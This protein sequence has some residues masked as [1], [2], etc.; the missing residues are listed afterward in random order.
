MTVTL[1]L[2]Q[3]AAD[4]FERV[5]SLLPAFAERA[6]EHDASDA[7]VAN[8]YALLKDARIFSAG[9]PVELGGDGLDAASLARLLTMIAKAC[10]ST[11]LALAM[12]THTVAVLAWR[13]RN[14]KA[15]VDA[16]L[17]RIAVEQ[18]VIITTGGSDWLE[19]S[20]TAEKVEGGFAIRG[21][22][23][24]ASGVPAGT[25]LNTSAVYDDPES[26]PTVLH[27]MVPL[28]AKGVR[29][30]PTWRAM[31]MRATASHLVHLEGYVVPDAAIALRRPKGKWHPLFHTIVMIAI[32]IIYSVYY[33]VAEAAR[34]AAIATAKKKPPTPQLVDLVGEMETELAAAR[35]ALADMLANASGTPGPE[36]TNRTFLGRVNLVRAALAAT[37][38][39]MEVT[40][41]AG[42]MR[43]HPVE[44][45]FRDIQG[46]RFHPLPTRPQRDLA[47]RLALGLDIDGRWE[48]AK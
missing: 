31:G 27:F 22:K 38:R 2:K 37:E 40:N 10:S 32:P 8:N 21:V 5:A 34:D 45:L 39:A 25:L 28:N 17:K 42:F 44:R 11:A 33:G 4:P 20:G 29:I 12:H 19:S 13:W 26:G 24:F 48:E 47:G 41:A 7:F 30:E 36:T 3:K 23:G 6:A 1:A 43:A 18:I 46:A 9:V 35:M 15:P 14:Q 16:I